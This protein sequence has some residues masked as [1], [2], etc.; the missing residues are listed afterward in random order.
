MRKSWKVQWHMRS[1][2]IFQSIF[3][4]CDCERQE[5]VKSWISQTSNMIGKTLRSRGE[6]ETY[7]GHN[8]DY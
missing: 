2:G 6:K 3:E 7:R 5:C 4:G 1:A 8:F